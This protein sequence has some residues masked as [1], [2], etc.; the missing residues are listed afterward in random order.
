MQQRRYR[1]RL[2]RAAVSGSHMNSNRCHRFHPGRRDLCQQTRYSR[3]GGPGGTDRSSK[4]SAFA[5]EFADT[6]NEHSII[7]EIDVMNAALNA[8]FR[9]Q[10]RQLLI[11]PRRTYRN[12]DAGQRPL[13]RRAIVQICNDTLESIRADGMSACNS[14]A[15]MRVAEQ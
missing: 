15:A 2:A 12:L 9:K 6:L 14:D 11:R 13:E 10:R 1:R 7:R 5:R 3:H 8:Y 4:P